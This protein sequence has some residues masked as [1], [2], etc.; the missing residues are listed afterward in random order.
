MDASNV[1]GD[2]PSWPISAHGMNGRIE[3]DGNFVSLTRTRMGRVLGGTETRRVPVYVIT[4]VQWT[5]AGKLGGRIAFSIGGSNDVPAHAGR[6]SWDA[7]STVNSVTF[8]ASQA[9]QMKRVRDAIELAIAQR[10]RSDPPSKPPLA[11]RLAQLT[12]LRDSGAVS[13]E[14]YAAKRAEILAEL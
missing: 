14:E 2:T 11:Q 1:P 13:D 5:S 8:N 3:F 6:P 7:I 10:A 4:A 12:A 9:A